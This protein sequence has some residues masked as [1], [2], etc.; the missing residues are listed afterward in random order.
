MLPNPSIILVFGLTL[1]LILFTWE[2][3]S[4]MVVLC[5]LVDSRRVRQFLTDEASML[6]A[7]TLA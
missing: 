7:N 1:I 6:V 4:T 2:K 3:I 5:I